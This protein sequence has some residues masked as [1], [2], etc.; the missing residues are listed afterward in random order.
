MSL[1]FMA[2]D[3]APM[4]SQ[5]LLEQ[6]QIANASLTDDDGGGDRQ[7]LHD[8]RL[9]PGQCIRSPVTAVNSRGL[10][11]AAEAT[12]KSSVPGLDRSHRP[13]R[14]RDPQQNVEQDADLQRSLGKSLSQG[15]LPP[16][17][18]NGGVR[19]VRHHLAPASIYH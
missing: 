2:M 8:T 10:T 11:P 3:L 19:P 18:C 6:Y 5:L 15:P 1:D 4:A 12:T 13:P 14:L 7:W 17:R 9:L 16:S